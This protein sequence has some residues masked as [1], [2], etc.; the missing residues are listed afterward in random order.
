[1]YAMQTL[2]QKYG[3]R[4]DPGDVFIM[5]DPFDGG[6]HLPDI[7]MFKP[8]FVGRHLLGYSILVAHHNDM[9]GRVPGGVRPHIMW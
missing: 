2:F 5:N 8:V 3:G 9:G 7:F 4:I 6:M 1:M